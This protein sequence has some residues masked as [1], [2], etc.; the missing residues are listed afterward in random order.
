[1]TR[2]PPAPA[3]R[4]GD[5]R[6]RSF[7]LLA[8]PGL[9]LA[10]ALALGLSGCAGPWPVERLPVPAGPIGQVIE[11][12]GGRGPDIECRGIS[13]DRCLSAGQIDD[14]IGGVPLIDIKRIIVSCEGARCTAA[15][16][17]MRMDVVLQD[18][19]T[20]EVARGGYGEFRQP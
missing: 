13:R 4:L 15:G 14:G 11:R 5:D 19:T 17:A 16:G 3:R 10:L 1:M 2:N 12:A 9:A 20:V 8:I 6:R 7:P 18:G